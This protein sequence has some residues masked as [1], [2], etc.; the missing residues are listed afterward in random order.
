MLSQML[1]YL[2]VLND[3]LRICSQ[4]F[5]MYMFLVDVL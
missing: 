5:F 2:D 1:Q 3:D 4:Y